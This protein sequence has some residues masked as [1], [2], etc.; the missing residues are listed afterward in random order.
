[1]GKT[2]ENILKKGDISVPNLIIQVPV[3]IITFSTDWKINFVNEI[4]I[5]YASLYQF[6]HSEL[7]G[8]SISDI[9]IFPGNDLTEDLNE[10]QH[11]YS[12]EKEIRNIK[13]ADGGMIKVIIKGSP[14][15]NNDDFAGGILVV[16]D[17]KVPPVTQQSKD[18][19][20]AI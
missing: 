6:R 18:L 2:V 19:K 20:P 4:F 11:G 15:F 7:E 12:F 1:M 3:G 14:L 10:L 5:K 13:T 8:K 9:S 17:F 16:E